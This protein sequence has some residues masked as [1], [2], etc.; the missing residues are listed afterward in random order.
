MKSVIFLLTLLAVSSAEEFT[1]HSLSATV[2]P[3]NPGLLYPDI[4]YEYSL[5]END[6]VGVSTGVGLINRFTYVRK[7]GLLCLTASAGIVVPDHDIER[8]EGFAA[9]SAEYRQSLG[10]HLFSRIVGSA[11]FFEDLPYDLPAIPVLQIGFGWDF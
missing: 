4:G 5:S 8:R 10:E 11:V 3:V 2:I 1:R 6:A 9:L 7:I